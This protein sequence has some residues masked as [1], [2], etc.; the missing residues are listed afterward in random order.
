MIDIKN[1]AVKASI[2][3]LITHLLVNGAYPEKPTLYE[4]VNL[5]VAGLPA[6]DWEISVKR[7]KKP[8]V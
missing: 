6:G 8:N 2:Q 1:E 7:V 4:A 5:E 3:T